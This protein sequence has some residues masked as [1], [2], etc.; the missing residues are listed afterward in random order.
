MHRTELWIIII[1]MQGPSVRPPVCADFCI[2]R[3]MSNNLPVKTFEAGGQFL[4]WATRVDALKFKSDN[5]FDA[6]H[7]Q[8]C[9]EISAVPGPASGQEPS[10]ARPS[11]PDSSL[12]AF[13]TALLFPSHVLLF[14]LCR[15]VNWLPKSQEPCY[16]VSH[17]FCLSPTIRTVTSIVR[18]LLYSSH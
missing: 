14:C 15:H 1:G 13:V 2:V 18:A 12:V 8:L 10:Q 7:E 5:L 6:K 4:Q 16:M 17:L 9:K 3:H 11:Q